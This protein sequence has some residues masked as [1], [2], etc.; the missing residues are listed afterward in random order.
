V[1]DDIDYTIGSDY[2]KVAS[3]FVKRKAYDP[4]VV[5][6]LGN[7]VGEMSVYCELS[8]EQAFR[9][10]EMLLRALFGNTHY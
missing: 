4:I 9:L 2:E 5:I 3:V 10:I 1:S 8:R 6:G 7:V